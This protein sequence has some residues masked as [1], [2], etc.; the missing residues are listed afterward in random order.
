MFNEFAGQHT[1]SSTG[2]DS[3]IVED[4]VTGEKLRATN[5]PDSPEFRRSCPRAGKHERTDLFGS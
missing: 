4:E 5:S 1:L 3:H 2:G